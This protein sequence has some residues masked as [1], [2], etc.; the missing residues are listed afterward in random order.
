[1]CENIKGEAFSSSEFLFSS[2]LPSQSDVTEPT[3]NAH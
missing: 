2:I 1:M 3:V